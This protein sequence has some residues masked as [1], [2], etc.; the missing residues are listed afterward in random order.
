M[1]EY[2]NFDCK[3]HNLIDMSVYVWVELVFQDRKSLSKLFLAVKAAT[4][5]RQCTIIAG[6]TRNEKQNKNPG[7]LSYILYQQVEKCL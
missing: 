2:G 5:V 6:F 4:A 3:Q 7:A 1:L